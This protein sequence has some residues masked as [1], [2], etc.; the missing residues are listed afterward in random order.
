M[1]S[2]RFARRSFLAGLGGAFGLEIML[3]NLE[4]AAQGATSP[5]RMMM[6]HFPI[7][8]MRQSF[9]PTG[10][11][12]APVLPKMLAPFQTL[13]A[14]TIILFGL[15]D[16][17][18]C[19]GGGGHE[20]GT[21]FT[22]TGANAPGTRSN[23]GEGDDGVAGGPSFDQIFL[24]RI[25]AMK[26]P[27]AGY[28]S[29]LAD[30]RVDSLETST[31]CLCYDYATRSIAS[32]NPGGN[33]TENT[34][35]LPELTP[36]KAYST[37]FTGFMP[38]GGTPTNNNALLNGFKSRKSVLDYALRE[39]RTLGNLCPGDQKPKIDAHIAA[40][41]NMEDTL[42]IQITNAMNSGGAGAGS[43]GA[44]GAS[45]GNA[46]CTVPAA[47]DASLKG[48]T[49]SK[50]NYGNESTTASDEAKHE[51]IGKAHA[52]VILG[53][54]QCDIIRVASFQWSPGTNHVSFGG[55]YPASPNSF[56]MH[57]P[58]SH[59]IPDSGFF[60]G[61]V[62]TGT[63]ANSSLYQFLVNVATWYNQKTADILTSFKN[64]K[65]GFGNS[66]LDYTVIPYLTEV[67][68]PSHTRSPKASMIFGGA[69]LGMKGGQFLNF[70]SQRPQVDVWLTVMQALA[71]NADP[72]SLLP[73]DEKFARSGAGPIAGLW[74][75]PA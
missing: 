29:T 26:R 65:D 59:R 55:M 61:P 39:L 68:D 22:T 14:D 46:S 56:Y 72:L 51:A 35:L 13:L 8:T 4:A 11:Q 16:R 58:M 32:A 23:G 2:Y 7:G 48:A 19:P 70:S 53:A 3:R 75:K 17:L 6:S 52:A 31:Q 67:G 15:A 60:T 49:G 40:I 1:R 41:Q 28:I 21:P 36:S 30:A 33:I 57:H 20:A 73:S 74:A 27:G 38:G 25:P 37:L 18:N 44:G 63:D 66:I 10:T 43:G 62:L 50:F 69:K 34:P 64:A 45:N 5:A 71:Q 12:T 54:F 47:P 24:K 9:L 42:Q